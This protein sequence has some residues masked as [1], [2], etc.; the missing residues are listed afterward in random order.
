MPPFSY[1]VKVL[2]KIENAHIAIWKDA[3]IE[4]L[5]RLKLRKIED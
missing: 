1:K 5:K 4:D 2:G 3:H